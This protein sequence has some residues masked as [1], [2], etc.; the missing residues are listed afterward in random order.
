MVGLASV[1]AIAVASNAL[2]E[3]AD[4][5]IEPSL[6]VKLGSPVTS[7]LADVLV[8]RGDKVKAGQVVAHVESAV[9]RSM[10]D[11][12]RA[13]SE[14]TSE[15]EAKQAILEQKSG[16]VARKRGL[17][18]SAIVSSQDFENAQAEYN[19]ATQELSLAQLNK[20]MAEIELARTQAQLEQRTIRSPI[21]GIVTRRTLGPG[22]YVSPEVNIV[23]IARVD[24][25]NVETYLPVRDYG[26]LKVGQTAVVRPNAPVGG[27]YKAQ[28]IVVDQIFDAASGT[29]GVRLKLA[30][31]GNTIPAGLR[32]KVDFE[33]R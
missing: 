1:A 17:Q 13:R 14:S 33:A 7:V 10:V 28:V 31:P 20:K 8:E 4:C 2:A 32:C 23:T 22:E 21:D 18:K 5:V 25:L 6:L 11:Y 30:N 15:I 24:P 12:N 26:L 16:I 29:F 9:E 27:E 3:P 19:V